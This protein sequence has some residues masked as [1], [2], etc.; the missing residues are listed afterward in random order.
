M[1]KVRWEDGAVSFGMTPED[2]R[3]IA[4]D[5]PETEERSHMDHPDFRV[6]GK[7][8]ATLGAPDAGWGMVK[9]KPDEQARLMKSNPDVFVPASGAWGKGGATH[10]RLGRGGVDKATLRAALLAAWR[11]VAPR[12]LV[13]E[14]GP[15]K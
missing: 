7:I 1:G 8:F 15:R 11:N 3:R 5:L 9:L 4:L 14:L 13:E 12:R 6:K 10:V 2:F